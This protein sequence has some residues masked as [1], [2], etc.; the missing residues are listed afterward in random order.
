VTAL[1]FPVVLI[2][3]LAAGIYPALVLSGFTPVQV[4]K[5]AHKSGVKGM[6][7]RE[8]LVVFQ[9]AVSI[10]LILSTFIVYDQ[11]KYMLSQDTGFNKDH[12]V[13][14]DISNTPY[15]V[16]GKKYESVK[17]RLLSYHG[18]ISVTATGAV[19]GKPG[20]RGQ[21][22]FPEGRSQKDGLAVEYIAVDHDYVKT[23][24]LKVIAGR[25]FSDLHGSDWDQAL[26]INETAVEAMGWGTPENS[27]GKRIDSPSGYPEGVVVGVVKDYNHHDLKERIWQTVF[28]I[29]PGS[30]NYFAVKFETGNISIVMSHIE[31]VWNEMYSGYDFNYFFLN[32]EYAAQYE[33]EEKLL[34]I[35]GTFA[36]LAIFISCLGL[37]GLISY[38]VRQKTKEIGIRK[39][40]GGTVRNITKILT[41]E[42]LRLIILAN[43][44][45][46]PL[47][48]IAM[49][50]WL[51][52]F[53]YRTDLSPGI[54]ILTALI[55]LSIAL[56]SI[57]FQTI[58]ATAA[59]PVNTLRYE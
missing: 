27:I 5:G 24:G 6:K 1:L 34:N 39:V 45:A 3:G 2:T 55:S 8:A 25:D 21:F 15:A 29:N 40:L 26:L 13:V 7:L 12:V 30:M 4:L 36:L 49:K 56:I 28:D 33:S 32:E 16:R 52:D 14:I 31:Q 59:N 53:A 46:L 44:I 20:W 18:I 11:F 50:G 47:T 43:I 51:Q 38:M 57:S 58:K 37:L 23:L 22:V 35:F 41:W 10:A 42:F 54:F 9:F 17:Q 19:P 48:Y